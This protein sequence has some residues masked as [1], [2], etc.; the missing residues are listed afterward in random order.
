MPFFS[1]NRGSL[2]FKCHN[3]CIKIFA[4]V[5]TR[6]RRIGSKSLACYGIVQVPTGPWFCRKCESQERSARVVYIEGL[7]LLR[8]YLSDVIFLLKLFSRNPPDSKT[9]QFPKRSPINKMVPKKPRSSYRCELCPSKDGALKKTDGGVYN[10]LLVRLGS[11]CLCF[12]IPE[13]RFGN[14]T[15]MEPIILQLV[16]TDRY[17]KSC[18]ICEEQG[19]ES[20][21]SVGACMQCNKSGC[22]Q[23]FHVTCAQA[24]GL[25]CEEAGNLTDNVKYCGYC[26]YHY[27]KLVINQQSSSKNKVVPCYASLGMPCLLSPKKDSHIKIIPAFKPI[28]ADN[29]TPEPSPEKANSAN[30]KEKPTRTKAD[31]KGKQA[32][33]TNSNC[34]VNN[35]T[36]TP[37]PPNLIANVDHE[38][39]SDSSASTISNISLHNGIANSSDCKSSVTPSGSPVYNN[40]KPKKKSKDSSGTSVVKK[41]SRIRDLQ[42]VSAKSAAPTFSS[43]YENFISEANQN[44]KNDK[45]RTCDFTEE[46]EK[47]KTKH[48]SIPKELVILRKENKRKFNH[49]RSCSSHSV[50]EVSVDDSKDYETTLDNN[51]PESVPEP[52]KPTEGE[53]ILNSNNSPPIRNKGDSADKNESLPL[54][55]DTE[56]KTEE[57][58]FYDIPQSSYAMPIPDTVDLMD[59]MTKQIQDSSIVEENLHLGPT[60]L[61]ELLEK[62]WCETSNFLLGQAQHF[63][64]AS[65][66]SCLHELRN[67]N[68]RLE[69]QI[70]DLVSRRD[71]LL[72]IN[73]RL[74]V[75]PS[76]SETTMNNNMRYSPLSPLDAKSPDEHPHPAANFTGFVFDN[77]MFHTT[78][79]RQFECSTDYAASFC[80]TSGNHNSSV[81]SAPHWPIWNNPYSNP[82]EMQRVYINDVQRDFNMYKHPM[83]GHSPAATIGSSGFPLTP[84][85]IPCS[86]IPK[87]EGFPL[88]EQPTTA[89]YQTISPPF[90]TPEIDDSGNN[91]PENSVCNNIIF[92]P[93][94]ENALQ[95]D[96]SSLEEER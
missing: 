74:K 39:L 16:P 95:N 3:F 4:L 76:A 26:H 81:S 87:P 34:S 44:S 28:P 66:I 38:F 55:K 70:T 65:M 73:A 2:I 9:Q 67:E 12:Y 53:I 27:Q 1:A 79:Q 17:N 68:N 11:C 10:A 60:T 20:K 52:I 85:P 92:H 37:P 62:Q 89:V 57:P 63:D 29:A 46:P 54:L 56:I 84:S 69:K 25:L 86:P 78:Q 42:N 45:K 71:T 77:S 8:D 33:T 22:K 88:D 83:A 35:S 21:A 50:E 19:K 15:T 51:D 61:E 14:V 93:D 94:F 40:E 41:S 96:N 90:S 36:D 5:T 18:Y 58:S 48:S 13:V 91:T 30:S 31:R 23:Y 7:S 6:P 64:I 59:K 80:A 32:Y 75:L 82:N 72:A 47:K 49:D 43:M 24:A